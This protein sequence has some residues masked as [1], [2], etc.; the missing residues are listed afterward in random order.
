[1]TINLLI[2]AFDPSLAHFASSFDNP[3]VELISKNEFLNAEGNDRT[4]KNTP[5]ITI[6]GRTHFD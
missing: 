6:S 1:M 2:S 5:N 3:N 4:N